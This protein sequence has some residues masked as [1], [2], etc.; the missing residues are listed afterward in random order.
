MFKLSHNLKQLT[1]SEEG[2]NQRLKKITRIFLDRHVDSRY[3][4]IWQIIHEQVPQKHDPK[5]APNSTRRCAATSI[6]S[7]SGC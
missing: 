4:S 1:A 2:R 5:T 3:K 7:E 6:K